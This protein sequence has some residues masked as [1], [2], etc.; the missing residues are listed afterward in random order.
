MSE[1][2]WTNYLK[3]VQ[4]RKTYRRPIQSCPI[5]ENK[6][7]FKRKPILVFTGY[8]ITHSKPAVLNKE[9]EIRR[10]IV[11]DKTKTIITEQ[12]ITH[13]EKNENKV[14]ENTN[15]QKH[16]KKKKFEFMGNPLPIAHWLVTTRYNRQYTI[17]QI[18]SEMKGSTLA[19]IVTYYY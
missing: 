4:V 15:V 9:R 18:I 19:P 13:W 8:M 14:T 16:Q 2:C 10:W 7:C 6:A 5:N 1:M 12:K 11:S 17:R 3:N